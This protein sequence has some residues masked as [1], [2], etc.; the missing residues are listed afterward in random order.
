MFGVVFCWSFDVWT[1]IKGFDSGFIVIGGEKGTKFERN[2]LRIEF[3]VRPCEED[4]FVLLRP[5]ENTLRSRRTSSCWLD[6]SYVPLC[7]T[8][9]FRAQR[10]PARTFVEFDGDDERIREEIDK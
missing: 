6:V 2:A 7:E 5:H 1:N 3:Q 4:A 9:V 8:G 10:E